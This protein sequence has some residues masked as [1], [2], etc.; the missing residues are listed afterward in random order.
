MRKFVLLVALAVASA[1]VAGVVGTGSALA[2][3]R[4]V[5]AQVEISGNCN[6]PS[7]CNTAFG[8]T[9]GLWI[10]AALN[11]DSGHTADFT[12]AGCGHSV[13]T[14]PQPGRGIAG[15]G[16]GPGEGTWTIAPSLFAA[17][18]DGAFPLDVA[19]SNG[20]PADVPYYEIDLG[21]GFLVAAPVPVGHYSV[22]GLS[23]VFGPT[24]PGVSFQTQVAP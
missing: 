14:S 7:Y 4:G 5:V 3:G 10:W 19:I 21:G 24:P 6:N 22:S 17:L 11:N 1:V 8:G 12:F 9:G 23:F 13:G 18:G 16:G 15:A 20:L 2:Y